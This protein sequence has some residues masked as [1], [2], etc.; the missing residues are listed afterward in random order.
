MLVRRA[1]HWKELDLILWSSLPTAMNMLDTTRL[2]AFSFS[3]YMFLFVI[4]LIVAVL[5]D[6]IDY[7]NV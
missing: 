5:L 4:F 2:L 7:V 1:I 6:N 3:L